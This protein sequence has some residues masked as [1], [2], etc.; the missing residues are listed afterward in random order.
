VRLTSS[1][2]QVVALVTK[3]QVAVD[4]ELRDRH[5]WPRW[6][7]RGLYYQDILAYQ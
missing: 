5:A 2:E 6:R 3:S 7:T 1:G 4:C